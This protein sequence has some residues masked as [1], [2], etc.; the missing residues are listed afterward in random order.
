MTANAATGPFTLAACAEMIYRDR[1]LLERIEAITAR[2]LEVEIWDWT[3]P[4]KDLRAMAAT[5][6][7]FG[8]MTGYVSGTLTDE[9][10]ARAFLE[11]AKRSTE[12]A[13]VLGCTRLNFHGTGLGPTGLPVEPVEHVTGAMWARAVLTLTALAELGRDAGVVFTMENLNLPVDHP[14]TPFS[15]PEDTLALVSAVDSPALRMNLDL[16]HAQIGDGQLI[17]TCRKSLPWIGEIQVAD[18]PGRCEP[19][20]GEISYRN[21]AIA[22]HEMGY[23][24]V[25]AMEAWA[26]GDSDE[27]LDTFIA[28]FSD[29]G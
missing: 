15:H 1:P 12:A 4:D 19:G 21:I 10:G 3:K 18:V 28:T 7:V 26:K 14:G 29:I 6:A 13:A 22:L 8:S 17:E 24:G 27:A 23:T 2:G 16:Y 9:E 11:S 5:G 25:V 20:T